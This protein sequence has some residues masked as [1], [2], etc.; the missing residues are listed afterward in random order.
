MFHN[1]IVRSVLSCLCLFAASTVSAAPITIV[2]FPSPQGQ[3]SIYA[4]QALEASWSQTGT[5]ADVSIWASLTGSLDG[6]HGTAYLTDAL[7]PGTTAAG[8]LLAI[9]SYSLP[10]TGPGFGTNVALFSGLRLGPGTYYLTL[11]N[12]CLFTCQTGGI[13]DIANPTPAILAA[14]VSDNGGK[15]SHGINSAFPPAS[16]FSIDTHFVYTV[17]GTP[18][19]TVPEP[20][21]SL[22]IALAVGGRALYNGQ[23][24]RS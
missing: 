18:A 21:T 4:L 14:G 13:W 24:R 15:I 8:H 10:P 3:A 9:S 7:G 1:A 17:T 5:Y 2:A 16:D 11:W 19:A 12:E 23:R 20:S 6:G 22:L